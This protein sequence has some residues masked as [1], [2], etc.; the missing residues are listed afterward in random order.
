[1]SITK[2]SLSALWPSGDV[3]RVD[4]HYTPA[5]EQPAGVSDHILTIGLSKEDKCRDQSTK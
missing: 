1:M 5:W 3:H 4:I 2:E